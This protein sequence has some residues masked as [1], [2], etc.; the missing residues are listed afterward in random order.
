VAITV[1][2]AS[3]DEDGG[4]HAAIT[5]A[6]LED[7]PVGGS[8]RSATKTRTRRG[9]R[10]EI[11]RQQF[12]AL[13]KWFHADTTRAAEQY[14]A[15]RTKVIWFLEFHGCPSVASADLADAAL[16]IAARRVGS[17]KT[18][19]NRRFFLGTARK[20]LS[21]YRRR[22]TARSVSLDGA[23][24]LEMTRPPDDVLARSE[25]ERLLAGRLM[26]LDPADR[27][28]LI[29]Y[30]KARSTRGGRAELARRRGKA[31][32]ALYTEVHRLRL[33]LRE[34]FRTEALTRRP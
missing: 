20:L 13:L 26:A 15:T 23:L 29:Q 1:A 11:S 12:E 19:A 28:L 6:T 16:S 22:V 2:A 31:V 21:E 9:S 33:K 5:E 8:Q 4:G 27:E 3:D 10:Q 30:V 25:E 14:E 18:I 32:G 17:G 34:L 24:G 7:V